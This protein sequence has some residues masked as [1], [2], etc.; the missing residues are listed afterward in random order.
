MFILISTFPSLAPA[1]VIYC[2]HQKKHCHCCHLDARATIRWWP[3]HSPGSSNLVGRNAM[4]VFVEISLPL[5][6]LFPFHSLLVLIWVA[7]K[8]VAAAAF[9]AAPLPA[10]YY[11][12]PPWNLDIKPPPSHFPWW[13]RRRWRC[14]HCI[15][16]HTLLC[17]GLGGI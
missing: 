17:M 2:S 11:P 16:L 15:V 12:S 9:A 3:S 4:L 5:L 13:R 7:S 10:P 6:V 1:V 8:F 14:Y